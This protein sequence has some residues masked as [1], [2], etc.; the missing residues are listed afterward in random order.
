[1]DA[2]YLRKP[3]RGWYLAGDGE[4]M[5]LNGAVP[6]HILWPEPGEIPSGVDQQLQKA[7]QVL[8][9]EVKR[10]QSKP[11]PKILNASERRRKSKPK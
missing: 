4:D 8:V 5:E 1:M 3:F 10:W 7:V 11:T 2:G 9:K 6:N